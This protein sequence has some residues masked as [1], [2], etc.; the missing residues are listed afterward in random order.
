MFFVNEFTLLVRSRFT[1][2]ELEK[3]FIKYP[4]F[5]SSDVLNLRTKVFVFQGCKFGPEE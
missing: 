4:T 2:Q 1:G 5:S 3:V